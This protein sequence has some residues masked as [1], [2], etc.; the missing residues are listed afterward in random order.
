MSWPA[1]RWTWAG[2]LAKW[3]SSTGV[4]EASVAVQVAEAHVVEDGDHH[5]GHVARQALATWRAA[6]FR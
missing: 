4:S 5:I 3:W 2:R 6:G 1:E